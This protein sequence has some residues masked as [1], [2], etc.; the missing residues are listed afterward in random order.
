MEPKKSG[1][2]LGLWL[3]PVLMLV[4]GVMLIIGATKRG[5]ALPQP[6]PET[7]PAAAEDDYLA[8]VRADLEK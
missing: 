5:G 2:T 4:L 3:A 6:A 8:K 7:P 1:V